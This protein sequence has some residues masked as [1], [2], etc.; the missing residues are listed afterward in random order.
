VNSGQVNCIP[1][2]DLHDAVGAGS[3]LTRSASGRLRLGEDGHCSS[4]RIQEIADI[5]NH[6]VSTLQ[7]SKKARPN[8]NR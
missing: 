3:L 7:S 2:M 8:L 6:V 4:E 1:E 5:A